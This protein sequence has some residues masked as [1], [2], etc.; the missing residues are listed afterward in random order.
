MPEIRDQEQL[1]VQMEE[2]LRENVRLK[3]KIKALEA[4]NQCLS[5]D[6]IE[7]Q[8]LEQAGLESQA[9]FQAMFNQSGVGVAL[10]DLKGRFVDANPA[11]LELSG[12]TLEEL[13]QKTFLDIT[14]SDDQE[15][16][17][18]Q[19]FDMLEGKINT[20]TVERRYV[21]KN[22][23][24]MFGLSQIS[25]VHIPNSPTPFVM[26]QV[27]NITE[28][29]TLQKQFLENEKKH[30]LVMDALGV[31]LWDWN[32]V[33]GEVHYNPVWASIL[34]EESTAPSYDFW[35][36]RIHPDDKYNILESLQ[37][38]FQGK[39][40]VWTQEHRLKTANNNWKWVNGQGR[41][42]E[43]MANGLPLRMIGTM[44]D[45]SERK[46]VENRLYKTTRILEET[47][48]Q[49]P[50][51]MFI[52]EGDVE[53]ATL[54]I[55]NDTAR[56]LMDRFA[57]PGGHEKVPNPKELGCHLYSIN[58]GE[59]IPAHR[60]P[61]VRAIAGESIK[62]E[63]FLVRN[64]EG[65]KFP[66][67]INAFPVYGKGGRIMAVPVTLFDISK[68][69]EME[70]DLLQLHKMEAVGTLAGGISHDFNNILSIIIGHAEIALDDVPKDSQSYQSVRA[71]IDACLRARDVVRQLLKFARK[72]EMSLQPISA[73]QVIRESLTLLRASIPANIE[74]KSEF[75]AEKDVIRASP[76]QIRQ[77]LVNLCTNA[78]QAISG[79]GT[80]RIAT[81]N[82]ELKSPWPGWEETKPPGECF[83]LIIE[84]S[85]EGMDPAIAH[86]ALEPY[87][88]TKDVGQGSGMGLAV[89]HGL[90]KT[91]KGFMRVSSSRGEGVK[92]EMILPLSEKKAK[93]MAPSMP[94]IEAGKATV[95]VLVVDDERSLIVTQKAML[96]RM[97]YTAVGETDA[98]KALEIYRSDPAKFDLV[99]TDMSMPG[100]TGDI[101]MKR[102]REINPDVPVIIS[103]GYSDEVSLKKIR[104]LDV[105][106]IISKPLT[107]NDLYRA[108]DLALSQKGE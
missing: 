28:F 45:I 8:K 46:K 88:T 19:F 73:T 71:I 12:Y 14:A 87:F 3:E 5:N 105:Q 6:N 39:T 50:Y 36:S 79:Q 76:S 104:N 72:T 38:H 107:R 54:L 40:P 21:K 66:M 86:R 70:K 18:L 98:Q 99:I 85:G 77:I 44:T 69:L 59:E 68:K 100:M 48:Q 23:A 24:L 92:V 80:I 96:K 11:I 94:V 91:L 37:Q 31:G 7:K 65:D 15:T 90:I 56:Q 101:F 61:L 26:A 42:V 1:L 33:T 22:G 9:K 47:I 17:L 10:F 89:V 16:G 13:K 34:G 35:E 103:T 20:Y 57:L 81:D 75:Q 83:R 93:K 60:K 32:I 2:L 82:L 43:R 108:V 78:F 41:V 64:I 67:E 25:L 95:T 29:K 84:D 97:G 62:N 52:M 102:L 53:N 30:Q 49:A 27:V 51:A 4:E 58:D 74:I 106:A 55:A 63:R